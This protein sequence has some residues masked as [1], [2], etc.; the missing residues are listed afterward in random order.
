MSFGTSSDESVDYA[1]VLISSVHNDRFHHDK[2]KQGTIPI[3]AALVATYSRNKNS[4]Y[5]R[6]CLG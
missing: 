2:K 5:F 1:G 4:K 6:I 3:L